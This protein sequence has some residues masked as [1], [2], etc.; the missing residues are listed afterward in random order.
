MT[1]NSCLRSK[2]ARMRESRNL[3]QGVP[4]CKHTYSYQDQGLVYSVGGRTNEG[5]RSVIAEDATEDAV[6]V[7][8]D[9]NCEY[10]GAR[11]I[12]IGCVRG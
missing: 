12:Q 7:L 4:I 10:R 3:G 2:G 1:A 9:E 11:E 5:G 6:G 8:R